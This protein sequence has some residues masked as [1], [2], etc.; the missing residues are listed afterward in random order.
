MRE[1]H[2]RS[3]YPGL[4]NGHLRITSP[5]T[6]NYNCL[7]W[8]GG[9]DS[10]KWNPDPWGLFYWPSEEREDTLD[11]WIR[12]FTQ[13]GYAKCDDGSLES[14]FEKVVIYGTERAPN[15]M[16]RQL[17]SG[18]WTSKLGKIEDVEHEVEG[19]ANSHY[20][21]VLVFLRRALPQDDSPP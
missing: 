10:E 13:L 4:R 2:F 7:A 3:R 1:E 8:A 15:H 12:A 18:M 16:A 6:E 14:G 20:G 5:A 21:N 9:D 19:L 17:P 11:G